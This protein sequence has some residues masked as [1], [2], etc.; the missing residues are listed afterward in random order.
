VKKLVAVGTLE[1]RIIALQDSKR[2]LASAVV[3]DG[4]AALTITR[5]DLIALFD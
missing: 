1:E 3:G 4:G 5:E 2:L